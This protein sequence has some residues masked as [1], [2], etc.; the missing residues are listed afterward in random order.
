[1]PLYI[2][3]PRNNPDLHDQKE[4]SP[5]SQ[6]AFMDLFEPTR[7]SI[8]MRVYRVFC[9]LFFLGPL[10]ALLVGFCFLLFFVAV[11][12]LPSFRFLFKNER[13]FKTWAFQIV[14]PIMR[15]GL[16]GLGI[17]GVNVRGRLHPSA[18]TIVGNHLS[19]IETVIILQPFPVSYLAADWLSR[20][21]LI[22]Q[23][24][25]VFDFYFVDRAKHQGATNFLMHIANDP[26]MTPVLVFPEG[27]VTNGDAVLGFRSGA[28]VSDT[29]V[30]AVTIR[31]RQYLCPRSMSTYVWNENSFKFY[32]YQ[33]FAIPF[34]T[35]D[36]DLLEPIIWKGSSKSAA[37]RAVESQL[38]IANHL[39]ALAT[40]RSNRELFPVK[41]SQNE[42]GDDKCA[43]VD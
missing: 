38:Q 20:L 9:F 39:G 31:Y 7:P 11:M 28:Y 32:C 43:K 40:C 2:E 25:K 21:T 17:V 33:L 26:S 34:A 5:M 42:R 18:R 29:V 10:K 3:I 22:K 41:Q 27:K 8:P 23:T 4:L 30:Q 12:I 15:L 1:M 24:A 13:A 19:L 14:R 36:V 16:F 35:V 6:Q 37:E